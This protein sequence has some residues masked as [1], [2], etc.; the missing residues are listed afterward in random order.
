MISQNNDL[1]CDAECKRSGTLIKLVD[2]ACLGV[3]GSIFRGSAVPKAFV[4]ISF[5]FELSL[6]G[7]RSWVR[8][9]FLKGWWKDKVNV[10]F[11]PENADFHTS[12]LKPLYAVGPY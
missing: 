5:H 7:Y 9:G 2:S 3:V 4:R 1:R 6:V 11:H 8:L 12:G 10:R